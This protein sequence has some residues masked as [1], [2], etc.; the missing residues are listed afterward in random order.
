MN[1]FALIDFNF[2]G[3]LWLIEYVVWH[4][5]KWIIQESSC[6]LDIHTHTR[7]INIYTYNNASCFFS[8]STKYMYC[9]YK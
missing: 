2:S 9:I 8:Y 1:I 5:T 6:V 7:Y 3:G 4:E